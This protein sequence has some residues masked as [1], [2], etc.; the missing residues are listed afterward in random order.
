MVGK[1]LPPLLREGQDG[2][3]SADDAPE[4]LPV[5]TPQGKLY[6]TFGKS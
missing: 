4:G 5:E 6:I 1:P 2:T 3:M